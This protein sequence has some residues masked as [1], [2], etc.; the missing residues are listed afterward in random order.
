MKKALKKFMD[1]SRDSSGQIGTR[2]KGVNQCIQRDLTNRRY[3]LGRLSWNDVN[4][5]DAPIRLS[6]I[7]SNLEGVSASTTSYQMTDLRT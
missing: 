1:R 2:Y 7:N 5:N 6:T 4:P 3:T